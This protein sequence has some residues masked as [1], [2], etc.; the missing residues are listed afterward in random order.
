MN[1]PFF[2][3]RADTCPICKS[4]KSIEAFNNYNKPINLSYHIDNNDDLKGK[5][6]YYLKCNKCK[7]IFFPIWY[8]N[9]PYAATDS[10][11]ETYLKMF[12]IYKNVDP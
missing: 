1:K 8:D 2:F 6:I 12:K 7:N 5:Y 4:E 3:E 11:I 10:S 9:L